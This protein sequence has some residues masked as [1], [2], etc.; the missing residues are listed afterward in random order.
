MTKCERM[1]ILY[2]K[3]KGLTSNYKAYICSKNVQIVKR[4]KENK[5]YTILNI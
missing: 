2:Q 1:R 5:V 3:L 4:K